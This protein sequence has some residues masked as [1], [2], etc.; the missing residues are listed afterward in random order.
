M[1]FVGVQL[2]GCE[3]ISFVIDGVDPESRLRE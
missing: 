3:G 1:R 2:L